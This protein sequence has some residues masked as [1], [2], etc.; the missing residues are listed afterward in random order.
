MCSV[1]RQREDY[2]SCT[3]VTDNNGDTGVEAFGILSCLI[4]VR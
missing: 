1:C 4:C 3:C 2:D